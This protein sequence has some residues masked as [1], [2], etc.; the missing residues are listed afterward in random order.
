MRKYGGPSEIKTFCPARPNLYGRSC[1]KCTGSAATGS[2]SPNAKTAI[3][4]ECG[5]TENLGHILVECASP[6]QSII[7]KA[8][9]K[10]WHEKESNWPE[11]S[12]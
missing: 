4:Q 10:L 7:W 9:E 2:I 1:T 11:V 5:E 3:C 6:G 12:L 8:A